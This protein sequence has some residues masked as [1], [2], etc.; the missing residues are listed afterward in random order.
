MNCGNIDVNK[1]GKT[2]C[3]ATGRLSTLVAFDPRK[4]LF[5]EVNVKLVFKGESDERVCS[6]Q[7]T[8]FSKYM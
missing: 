2:D 3:I 7:G 4:G 5:I 6:D 8:L 1:D